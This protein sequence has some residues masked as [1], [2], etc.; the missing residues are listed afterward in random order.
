MYLGLDVGTTNVKAIL[1]EPDGRVVAHGAAPVRLI[2]TADGV[3]QDVGEIWS[4]TLSAI[5]EVLGAVNPAR[6]EAMGVSAQGGALQLLDA[7]GQPVGRAVSWLDGRG[8]RYDDGMTQ[9]LGHEWFAQH[10]G[11]GR[12]SMGIGQLLRLREECPERLRPPNQIG[13][14]GDVVVARLCGRRA[15]DATSLSIAMLYNPSLRAA[16]PELLTLLGV[17]EEQ[18]PALISPRS[19]AGRLLPEIAQKVG[20]PVGIPVSA[21]VHDQYAA[22]LGVGVIHSGDVMFG[23]GTAWVLLATTERLSPPVIH[24]A[25][26]CTHVLE[27]MYGQMLSLVNGGS[28]FA[29]A[30]RLLGLSGK[31]VAELDRLMET[32]S[33]GSDGLRFRPLLASRGGAALVPGTRG[34]LAGLQLT[35]KPAHVLRAV[36]EGL[37]VELARYLRF[38]Q[39]GGI[40]VERLVMCGGSAGSQVT[41]RIVSDVSGVPV[42][43]ATESEMSALGAAMIARGLIE[44]DADLARLSQEMTPPVRAFEPGPNVDLYRQLFDEYV[45][46]LP[47]VHS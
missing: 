41:P 28:A 17:Q 10:T 33:P 11:H 45:A 14:V 30:A 9:R 42:A 2:H 13:W 34:R 23:A 29:W 46:S 32:V 5:R 39:K 22:A 40:V 7:H 8:R 37:A 31:S 15:H 43:C 20:L 24:E 44:S 1:V 19:A 35:H 6:V 26:V 12:S 38:F 18:L 3:E 21:A 47:Q 36:V 27:G 25:L 4:A 16:D